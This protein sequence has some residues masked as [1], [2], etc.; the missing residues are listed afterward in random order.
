MSDED[1]VAL[2]ERFS[3]MKEDLPK[4][5]R[6]TPRARIQDVSNTVRNLQMLVRF[7]S[8]LLF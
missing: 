8:R 1:R 4:I 6:D 5:R 3:Q 7:L 2:V